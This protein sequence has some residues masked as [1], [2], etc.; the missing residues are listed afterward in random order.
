LQR[1]THCHLFLGEARIS[2][3]FRWI[4]TGKSP[5]KNEAERTKS[6]E[7]ARIVALLRDFSLQ[8]SHLNHIIKS[9]SS[10]ANTKAREKRSLIKSV[11][12]RLKNYRTRHIV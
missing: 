10:A 3:A 2:A 4:S 7:Q 9:L 12:R 8:D 11:V 1:L 6:N 5:C